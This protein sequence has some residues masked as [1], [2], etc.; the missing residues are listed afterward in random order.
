MNEAKFIDKPSPEAAEL[1]AKLGSIKR[2]SLR[3]IEDALS[4][5]Q[6]ALDAY[7]DTKVNA[8]LEAAVEFIRAANVYG[9]SEICDAILTLRSKP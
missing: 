7:A 6:S 2:L 3:P 9:Q 1:L 5:I 4:I 8:R